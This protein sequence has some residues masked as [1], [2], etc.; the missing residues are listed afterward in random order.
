MI[1]F[2]K[3]STIIPGG[4]QGPDRYAYVNNNPIRYNDPSGHD[5]GCGSADASQCIS[6]GIRNDP[7]VVSGEKAQELFE[8]LESQNDIAF[9]YPNPGKPEP[10][11]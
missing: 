4:V 10:N 1:Y 5:V 11:R 7:S 8:I 6:Y 9:K 3:R 2:R